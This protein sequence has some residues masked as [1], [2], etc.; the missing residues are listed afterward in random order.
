MH[1]PDGQV[2]DQR[3]KILGGDGARVVLLGDVRVAEAAEVHGVDAVMGGEKRDELA[4]GPP[5][6]RESVNQEHGSA[7]VSGGDVVQSRAVHRCGL[8]PNAGDRCSVEIHER[9]LASSGI[10]NQVVTIATD[11]QPR[12]SISFRRR[13]D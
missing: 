9:L 8:V 2:L 10:D 1:R 6:L 7:L 11:K 5:R 12:L 13:Y 4:E 3:V